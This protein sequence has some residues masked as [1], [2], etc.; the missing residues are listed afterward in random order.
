SSA[1][2]RRVIAGIGPG[3]VVL[4]HDA[5]VDSP[6]GSAQRALDALPT[7]AEALASRGLAAV[8]LDELVGAAS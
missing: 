6:A 7:I 4:L 1:V 8:T 2:A 5:D 3:G